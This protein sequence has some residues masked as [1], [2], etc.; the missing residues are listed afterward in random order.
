[1]NY[2]FLDL[3]HVLCVCD[4]V[5]IPNNQTYIVERWMLCEQKGIFATARGQDI[6]RQPNILYISTDGNKT[7]L[8]LHEFV[9]ERHP[10]YDK[11]KH[12]FLLHQLDLYIALCKGRNDFAINIITKEMRFMTWEETFLALRSDILPDAIRAKYCDITTMYVRL[13]VPRCAW[14]EV[15]SEFLPLS[16]CIRIDPS[17]K[18]IYAVEDYTILVVGTIT[19]CS[20]LK[21]K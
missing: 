19:F 6:N 13:R 9:D 10:Q 20:T 15:L 4:D 21:I 12:D 18:A 16:E 11:D 3:L 1:M 14:E 5:A 8:A 2:R 17:E 7:W